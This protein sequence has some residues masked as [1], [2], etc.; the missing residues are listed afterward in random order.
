MHLVRGFQ[1]IGR[2]KF[3]VSLEKPADVNI[4]ID[5]FGNGT[6]IVPAVKFTITRANQVE[7]LNRKPDIKITIYGAPYE[8]DPKY[9]LS[10]INTYCTL[11]KIKRCTW[12]GY[13]N[14]YNGVHLIFTPE[15]K[16]PI[17][18]NLIIN[19]IR[20][21]VKYDDQPQPARRCF[22][23]GGENHLA[24]MCPTNAAP[25]PRPQTINNK[26]LYNAVASSLPGPSFTA[27]SF[28][29]T[30]SNEESTTNQQHRIIQFDPIQLPTTT[31]TNNYLVCDI[32]IRWKRTLT[33]H[34]P[35]YLQCGS[36][37]ASRTDMF[38]V[39][40]RWTCP[41]PMPE[42]WP[43]TPNMALN[44]QYRSGTIF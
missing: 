11:A 16:K 28:D 7:E 23:C 42:P 1:N 34:L 25:G 6:Q 29:P 10:K 8:L 21:T 2:T 41:K 26:S 40:R 37:F 33:C 22:C 31:T 39:W 4:F 36:E 13:P 3:I 19:G 12:R 18:N 5:W 20:I 30:R 27:M 17:P 35:T 43:Q 15:I 44:E 24:A 38:Q 32:S 14:M 9:I